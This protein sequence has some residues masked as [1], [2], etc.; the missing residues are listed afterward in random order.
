MNQ[1]YAQ[2]PLCVQ[3]KYWFGTLMMLLALCSSLAI[4][5]V[6]WAAEGDITTVAGTGTFG[7][8]AADDG[9][10]ATDAKLAFPIGVAVDSN[11]NLF[12][13][14]S[15][16]HRIRRV[17]A[18]G[19]ITTVAGTGGGGYDAAHDGAPAEAASLNQPTDVAVDSEGNLFIF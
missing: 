16:H 2:T 17:D 9:G 7:Y 18:S 8:N 14:H 13:A 15:Y 10:P 4:S 12:I 19:I 3:A 11:G 6:V 1:N 5:E